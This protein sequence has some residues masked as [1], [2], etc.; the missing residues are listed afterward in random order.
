MATISR[1]AAN[2]KRAKNETG[3]R[4]LASFSFSLFFL[5]SSSFF[6]RDLR[7]LNLLF[8]CVCDFETALEVDFSSGGLRRVSEEAAIEERLIF[9]S[10]ADETR[11]TLVETVGTPILGAVAVG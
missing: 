7:K 1:G 10:G 9:S 8:L 6:F 4:T 2:L 5:S 11:P 3:G